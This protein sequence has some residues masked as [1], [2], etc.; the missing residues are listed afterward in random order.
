MGAVPHRGGRP[1][2]RRIPREERMVLRALQ[3]RHARHPRVPGLPARAARE[4]GAPALVAKH[5]DATAAIVTATNRFITGPIAKELGVPMLIATDIEEKDGVFT[6][7]A[8]G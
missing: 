2:R 5:V 1:A 6:G 4:P 7:K 3:G 8:R